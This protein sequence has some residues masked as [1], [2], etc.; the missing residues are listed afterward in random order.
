MSETESSQ[1]SVNIRQN[2]SNS[3]DTATDLNRWSHETNEY[4]HRY[5]VPV[6]IMIVLGVIIVST[7]YSKEF[8]N[9][10]AGSAS[11][12]PDAGH[13]KAEQNKSAR[14][15]AS[16]ASE[17]TRETSQIS[18]AENAVMQATTIPAATSSIEPAAASAP[19]T[20][21][22]TAE[23]GNDPASYTPAQNRSALPDGP[24]SP[25]DSPERLSAGYYQMLER[26]H[27]S[28][29]QAMQARRAHKIRMHEYR[30]VVRERIKQDRLD[31]YKHSYQSDQDSHRR[32]NAQMNSME[33]AVKRSLYRPI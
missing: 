19:S 30:T 9:L 15:A 33:Q 3:T 27:R 31:R 14:T 5:F 26:R 17:V 4:T 8:N 7:F 10:I 29:E 28:R 12:E 11:P 1:S 20:E 18:V 32:I 25:Y 23:A 16:E 2:D 6:V 24:K 21:S 13:A 22:R